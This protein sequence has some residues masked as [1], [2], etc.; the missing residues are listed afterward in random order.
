MA[1][2]RGTGRQRGGLVPRVN[3]AGLT[4]G[5]NTDWGRHRNIDNQREKGATGKVKGL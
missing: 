2:H 3:T 5:R 1:V 4:L